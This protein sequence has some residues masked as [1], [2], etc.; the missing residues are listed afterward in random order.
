MNEPLA[1]F[2]ARA[3]AHDVRDLLNNVRRYGGRTFD[4]VWSLQ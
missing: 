2:A 4:V 3:L 1:G